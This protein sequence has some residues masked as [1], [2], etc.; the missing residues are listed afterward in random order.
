MEP[1]CTAWPHTKAK[2]KYQYFM[3]ETVM[4]SWT[5]N[6]NV[7]KHNSAQQ[8]SEYSGPCGL[9]LLLKPQSPNPALTSHLHNVSWSL[10][11]RDQIHFTARYRYSRLETTWHRPT[12]HDRGNVD[13][14]R[15]CP[16]WLWT[17]N[18]IIVSFESRVLLRVMVDRMGQR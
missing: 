9:E 3:T 2:T 16:T 4:K 13:I 11:V 7:S 14:T 18:N 8:W 12:N 5:F 1:F 6:V 10:N 15:K 17:M